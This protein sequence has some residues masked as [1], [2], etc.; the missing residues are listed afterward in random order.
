VQLLQY[1]YEKYNTISVVGMAKNSGKTVTFN[2]LI[3]EAAEANIRLGITSTGRDGERLDIVTSTE[4]PTIY[5][6][7]GTLVATARD[8]LL[9][10]EVKLEILEVT[11][12]TTALGP[13]VIAKALN[14]GLVEIAGPTTNYQIKRVAEAMKYFGGDLV[15][16]DG[17]INRRT[18]ASPSITDATI[19]ATGAVLSRN[20]NKVV[21]DTLHQVKLF[22][23]PM[24]SDNE[25]RSMAKGIVEDKRFGVIDEEGNI[26]YIDISTSLNGGNIIGDAIKENSSHVIISGSL[27][28]KTLEDIMAVS[29]FFKEVKIIIKDGTRVFLNSK[30]WNYFIKRGICIEVLDKINTLAVTL[31]PISPYGYSF[32]PREFNEKM[33]EALYPIP[34]VDVA[35][36]DIRYE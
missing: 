33:K 7:E 2:R 17:A 27:V 36:E 16:V 9:A 3:E 25:V 26:E 15:L 29:P 18:A 19:I 31:N 10:S 14:S 21:E 13:V 24:V 12:F 34:V 4:K 30:D 1:A 20:I 6:N 28:K 35:L 23:L 32:N 5:I 11:N 22:N 8:T